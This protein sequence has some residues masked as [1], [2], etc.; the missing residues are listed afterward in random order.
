MI[1]RL[2]AS[3]RAD[4]A[5]TLP[6][7]TACAEGATVPATTLARPHGAP[8][9]RSARGAAAHGLAPADYQFAIGY[10]KIER[11]VKAPGVV[12]PE[13]LDVPPADGAPIGRVLRQHAMQTT[14]YV[15]DAAIPPRYDASIVSVGE[16][17][18]ATEVRLDFNELLLVGTPL[19]TGFDAVKC[20]LAQQLALRSTV[21]PLS[22]DQLVVVTL[23]VCATTLALESIAGPPQDDL[24]PTGGLT[25]HG[26]SGGFDNP[27]LRNEVIHQLAA[28]DMG[29]VMRG[30]GSST[31]ATSHATGIATAVVRAL[32]G[33][34]GAGPQLAAAMLCGNGSV[35]PNA[36]QLRIL[37][38]AAD[39]IDPARAMTLQ[40]VLDQ[41][42]AC[43]T[44]LMQAPAGHTAAGGEPP[45]WPRDTQLRAAGVPEAVITQRVP[46]LA[47]AAVRAELG[48]EDGVLTPAHGIAKTLARS[49]LMNPSNIQAVEEGL[50]ELAATA[51]QTPPTG[52]IEAALQPRL[53]SAGE[54]SPI[55]AGDGFL[56]IQRGAQD[57]ARRMADI[58][59][60]LAEAQ[61][62]RLRS[63][64]L[65]QQVQIFGRVAFLTHWG[66]SIP[67]DSQLRH[68]EVGQGEA[69]TIAEQAAKLAHRETDADFVALVQAWAQTQ[70][71]SPDTLQREAQRTRADVAA[72]ALHAEAGG[73]HIQ[74]QMQNR[75][76][77]LVDA[78]EKSLQEAIA[79]RP[80]C[81]ALAGLSPMQ[82]LAAEIER[83]E[84]ATSVKLKGAHSLSSTD[85]VGAALGLYR[86]AAPVPGYTLPVLLSLSASIARESELEANLGA[87][88]VEIAF[89]QQNRINVKT[90]TTGQHASSVG[91]GGLA[92]L[93]Q[94]QTHA[95]PSAND[96]VLYVRLPRTAGD[97]GGVADGERGFKGDR[98]RAQTMAA[99][100]R[101]IEHLADSGQT[102]WVPK[103]AQVCPQLSLARADPSSES[104]SSINEVDITTH[105]TAGVPRHAL[106][107]GAVAGLTLESRPRVVRESS[108]AGGAVDVQRHTETQTTKLSGEA[109]VR[110]GPP[111]LRPLTGVKSNLAQGG[112]VTSAIVTSKDGQVSASDSYRTHRV[113]TLRAALALYDNNLSTY[114]K[115]SVEGDARV[116]SNIEARIAAMASD[117][118][119][120]AAGIDPAWLEQHELGIEVTARARELR[121]N[122]EDTPPSAAKTYT[123][124]ELMKPEV[125][126]R[127]NALRAVQTLAATQS[128]LSEAAT[129][130]RSSYEQLARSPASYKPVVVY[131]AQRETTTQTTSLSPTPVLDVEVVR[132]ASRSR[133]ST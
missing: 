30:Q 125:A 48:H 127:L 60:E 28:I 94:G 21:A 11:T 77:K 56:T 18:R 3:G 15:Q 46:A 12:S 53:P 92:R 33:A 59:L 100:V 101:H 37:A 23:A 39:A 85:P 130:A 4:A 93:T 98:I 110:L 17:A 43:T 97:E 8:G 82:A 70:L 117:T 90:L 24:T 40:Q 42:H 64:A 112:T 71:R 104:E 7:S 27:S 32:A 102:D 5:L 133:A 72:A 25:H 66:Y 106:L 67:M 49:G 109:S 57:S 16:L 52:L 38:R 10:S 20:L 26:R 128:C 87:H 74:E 78:M 65:D 119:I 75:L 41:A 45:D 122:I 107:G 99:L 96:I 54:L 73:G 83:L 108:G 111:G 126:D 69:Q 120:R 103:L 86:A 118:A 14:G 132:Q 124:Y 114:A 51:R 81:G 63:Q 58:A 62:V 95:W 2:Q 61:S 80:T 13:G 35:Q 29:S 131:E 6:D 89:R 129:Q 34:D 1:G 116:R 68:R 79:P 31:S 50:R 88:G 36:L 105:L 55:N 76:R 121:A 19:P 22:E 84:L 47:L 91:V 123:S 44:V 113:Q 115:L 9:L